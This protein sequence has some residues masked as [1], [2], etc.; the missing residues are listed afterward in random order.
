M[1]LS[2]R[3]FR[4]P[5]VGAAIVAV[6]GIFAQEPVTDA[7]TGEPV[8]DAG[9]TFSLGYLLFAPIGAVYDQLSLVTDRQHVFILVSLAVLY[10]G[11]RAWLGLSGRLPSAGRWRRIL[12]EFG[13]GAAAFVGLVAFYAYGVL[14]PRPMAALRAY[15]PSLVIVDF[16]SHTEESHDGRPGLSWQDRRRWH[17]AAGFDLVYVTDHA[18]L[19]AADAASADNPARA[20]ERISLLPGLEVRLEG[21]HVLVLGRSDPSVGIPESE[22]WPVVIQTIP[23]NLSRVPVGEPGGRGGVQGIELVDADPRGLR[24]GWEERDLILALVDSLDLA[25]IAGSNHHGWGRAA[26]AWNLARVPG[27]QELPPE[28]VGRR[29]EAL[30]LSERAEATRIVERPRLAAALPSD[31]TLRR[32]TM[33]ITAL[34]R[35]AWHVLTSLTLPERL[36]WLGW[37]LLL[38]AWPVASAI[39]LGASGRLMPSARVEPPPLASRP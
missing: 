11:A 28:E 27:W 35:F 20:G 30:I 2:L 7:L 33:A 8:V 24:Q 36:A 3:S 32:A 1:P 21:Q 12:R 4:W 14:G 6:A 5:L 17:D 10:V 38:T 22:P 18:T 31:G 16:H 15:D 29:V 37:I 39:R 34:P 23:N 25:V 26:A 9:L 19:A 13:L